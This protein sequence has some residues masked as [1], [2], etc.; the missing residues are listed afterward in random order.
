MPLS[1]RVRDAEAVDRRVL[2]EMLYEAVHWDPQ[3]P[4]PAWGATMR[5]PDVARY[6]EGFPRG[7]DAGVVAVA[8]SGYCIGAA[9]YR[10]F[11]SAEPS[12]G[13]VDEATPELAIG[14]VRPYRGRGVGSALLEALLRRAA[15]EGHAS[16]SLS[17]AED[18]PALGLYRRFG[19][20]EVGRQGGA[21]TMSARTQ[22]PGL[23]S[24]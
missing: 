7:G 2:E 4:R 14:V 22:R 11:S 20:V 12:Y 16:L 17:V 18:N 23:D 8:K 5:R 19:F 21:V 24:P 6:I 13:F 10:L 3:V 15:A 9:W 1:F